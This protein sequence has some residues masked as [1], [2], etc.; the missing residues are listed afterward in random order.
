MLPMLWRTARPAI[1]P[2]IALFLAIPML[3]PSVP[4]DENQPNPSATKAYSQPKNAFV[5]K[6]KASVRCGPGSQFYSTMTLELGDAVDVYVETADGWS[7]IRPPDGSHNWIPANAVYLLPGGKSAEVS[8]AKT[9]AFIGSDSQQIDA[10]LFQTELVASQKVSI[11]GEAIQE[12]KDKPSLWFRIAPPPGE[13]RW[14]RSSQLG[15]DPVAK[16]TPPSTHVQLANSA[17]DPTTNP[18]QLASIATTAIDGEIIDGEIIDGEVVDGEVVDGEVVWSDEA[19]QIARIEEEIRREQA[20]SAGDDATLQTDIGP[21]PVRK[22]KIAKRTVFEQ[23]RDYWNSLQTDGSQPINAQPVAGVLGWLGISVVNDGVPT[24]QPPHAF[25]TPH[26]YR[27]GQPMTGGAAHGTAGFEPGRNHLLGG[28]FR[29]RQPYVPQSPLIEN[30]LDRLPRPTRRSSD[31]SWWS[32]L[33]SEGPL[34]GSDSL[35]ENSRDTNTGD[36]DPL[37]RAEDTF[38]SEPSRTLVDIPIST[39]GY[40]NSSP[41]QHRQE[42]PLPDRFQTPAIQEVLIQLTTMVAKPTEQWNLEPYRVSAKSWIELGESPLIRGE[43][44]LLLDRIEE[45]ESLR[46]RTLSLQTPPPLTAPPQTEAIPPRAAGS[47]SEASGWLVSV[48]T[49]LP[50]QPEFALTDDAG[51]VLAYVRPT[52][53]LNLRRYV[54]QPVTIYGA[55][56]YIPNLAAKQIIAERVVRLR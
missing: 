56:G 15:T 31:D 50:G 5:H 18:V 12:Q 27:R 46:T 4:A 55:P 24:A 37:T 35:V 48:H 32:A 10:L 20:E 26:G 47:G 52:T 1:A 42:S 8:V 16:P 49:S 17:H 36:R 7:G 22:K 29:S 38:A 43:A 13:F 51:K 53:G 21:V 23:D 14:V 40:Q 9:P 34:F 11:L 2:A 45:F 30:R 28:V 39:A 6:A 25:G 33:Q 19:E 3:A 41:L 54:Q 44:R